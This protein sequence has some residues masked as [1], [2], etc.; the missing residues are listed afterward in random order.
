MREKNSPEEGSRLAR[1]VFE[2]LKGV[3]SLERSMGAQGSFRGEASFSAEAD[4]EGLFYREEGTVF[5]SVESPQSEAFF[6]YRDYHYFLEAD[7]LAIDFRDP[8][9][10]GTRYVALHF[11]K[12]G[13]ALWARNF[14][15]CGQDLYR[16]FFCVPEKDHFKTLVCVSGPK[17]SYV[18]KSSYRRL[19]L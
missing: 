1:Q 10:W 5:P 14:H 4:S 6:V 13:S 3:W 16:H 9:R 8:S 7:S 17:K 12:K 18:L 2:A 11:Q 15:L 19:N